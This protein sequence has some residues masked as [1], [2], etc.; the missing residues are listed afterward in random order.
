[1]PNHTISKH[2]CFGKIL[3]VVQYIM[4]SQQ[5]YLTIMYDN[6]VAD[7]SILLCRFFF[8]R[9]MVWNAEPKVGAQLTEFQDIFIWL[10][11]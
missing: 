4:M 11:S 7:R 6:Y 9:F 5:T 2:A 1:M 3:S 10:S 8:S